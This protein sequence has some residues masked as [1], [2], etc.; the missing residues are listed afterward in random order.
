MWGVL[1]TG[2][3]TVAPADFSNDILERTKR[4]LLT[5]NCKAG[6]NTRIKRLPWTSA[7]QG[8]RNKSENI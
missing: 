5:A 2:R 6:F 8:Q 4:T 3:V 7:L 1:I